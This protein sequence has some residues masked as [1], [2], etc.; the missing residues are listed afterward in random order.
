MDDVHRLPIERM[1]LGRRPLLVKTPPDRVR[2]LAV[3]HGRERLRRGLLHIAQAAEVGE[4]PLASMPFAAAP[5]HLSA[6]TSDSSPK[7]AEDRA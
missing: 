7:R 6:R 5:G 2:R 1:S 4:Q 3:D